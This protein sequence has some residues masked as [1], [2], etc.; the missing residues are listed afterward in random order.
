MDDYFAAKSKLFTDHLSGGVKPKRS[1]V[2]YGGDPR[3]LELIEMIRGTAVDIWTYGEAAQWDV[4]AVEVTSDVAGLRGKIRAKDRTFEFSS[5]LIGA[6]NLQNILAALASPPLWGC[7][8]RYCNGIE[9][10]TTVPGRLEKVENQRGVALLVDYAHTPDALEKVLT[11]VRPLTQG[12]VFAVFGCGGDRD[13]GKRP[14]MGEIAARLSDV[15]IVTSDNPRSEAPASIV[16]EIEGGLRGSG[17]R[18]LAKTQNE[19]RNS[20][21]EARNGQWILPGGRPARS[22]S[23]HARIGAPG[24]CRTDRRQRPRRLSNSRQRKNSFR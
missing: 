2:I 18:K 22:D 6:A 5:S 17:K 19:N 10:L 13:R 14:V 9:R 11:A 16:A 23:Y 24:R 15:T 4:H 20:E 1:A 3:G 12:R 21:L 8:R 7:Q